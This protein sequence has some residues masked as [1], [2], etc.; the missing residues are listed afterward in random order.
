ML[1]GTS[2]CMTKRTGGESAVCDFEKTVFTISFIHTHTKRNCGDDD[3]AFTVLP[4]LLNALSV[5]VG[6][7]SVEVFNFEMMR[8]Q[9][10]SYL[11]SFHTGNTIYDP[12]LVWIISLDKLDHAAFRI[13]F[14]GNNFVAQIGAIE[15]LREKYIVT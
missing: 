3:L 8:L 15:R 7:P 13:F 4:L 6:H 11:L 2:K 14:L 9:S 1:L 12:S 10:H 5:V